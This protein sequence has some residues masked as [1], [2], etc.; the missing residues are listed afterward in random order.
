MQTTFSENIF[1]R[2]YQNLANIIILQIT[3]TIVLQ[4]LDIFD[5]ICSLKFSRLKFLIFFMLGKVTWNEDVWG[6]GI[7]APYILNLDTR[8]RWVISF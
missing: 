4:S 6:S 7:I 5:E 1:S 3:E 8:W 2:H